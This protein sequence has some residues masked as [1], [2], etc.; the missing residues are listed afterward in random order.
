MIY[1]AKHNTYG[2]L[3]PKRHGSDNEKY[4]YGLNGME[5]DDEVKNIKGSS[6]DFGAR[7][8]DPRVGRWLSRDPH[9]NKYP[10]LSSYNFATN[11]PIKFMDP[12]G[13]D[14][15][16]FLALIRSVYRAQGI[17]LTSSSVYMRWL[18]QFADVMEDNDSQ[19]LRFTNSGS[20][21]NICLHFETRDMAGWG[22]VTV[23]YN[24]VPIEDVPIEDF[25]DANLNGFEILIAVKNVPDVVSQGPDANLNA[26]EKLLSVI[27]ESGLHA[28][29]C[30]KIIESFLSGEI[31][32]VALI[33]RYNAL[34]AD[35]GEDHLSIT[36][37]TNKTYESMVT[38]V[39]KVLKNN[40][41]GANIGFKALEKDDDMHPSENPK[42]KKQKLASK[43]G[44]YGRGNVDQWINGIV[45]LYE[46]LSWSYD[47]DKGFGY[48]PL[49]IG[50]PGNHLKHVEKKAE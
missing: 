18:G 32:A 38:D 48:N 33:E 14:I 19:G 41:N 2:M 23:S 45:N 28:E 27:H 34:L 35:S 5:A 43:Y 12:D 24:G 37:G 16:D 4:R 21:S 50:K 25:A 36:P 39:K 10:S 20:R 15:I 40:V 3:L 22:Q 26:G 31:D 29:S 7:M 8:Y 1:S 30:A 6:Y 9:E 46:L 47:N 13:R 42:S 17:V 49:H 11:S 44:K